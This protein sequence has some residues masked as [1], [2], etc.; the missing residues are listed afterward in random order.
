MTYQVTDGNGDTV[1][2]LLNINVDD[3]TPNDITPDPA[4]I[5]NYV[6]DAQGTATESLGFFGNVGADIPGTVVFVNND[7]DNKL[8]GSINGNPEVVLTSDGNEILLSG[9]GTNTLMGLVDEDGD[10]VIDPGEFKILEVTL[11]PDGTNA[12]NDTYTVELFGTIDAG[13]GFSFDSF[14]GAPAGLQDFIVL[15]DPKAVDQD[16]D[17]VF[18]GGDPG[19]NEVNTS[20]F[21]IGVDA[22]NIVV[23]KQLRLDYVTGAGG[24]ESDIT[25][26]SFD[27]HYFVNN[28]SF[29]IIQTG[30]NANN[31]VDA[32]VQV[33]DSLD[34][35]DNNPA[36]AYDTSDLTDDMADFIIQVQVFDGSGNL[37]ED[38][39]NLGSFDD[40]DIVITFDPFSAGTAEG[41]VL[42][43]GL[44][45]TYEVRVTTDDG[46]SRMEITNLTTGPSLDY[47][48]DIDFT[49]IDNVFVTSPAANDTFDLGGFG[50]ASVI[51][52]DP[53]DI[54][55]D[56]NIL[57]QDNDPGVGMLN[58][59]LVPPDTFV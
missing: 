4:T 5:V 56:L 3:D 8:R 53:I 17:L 46:F 10:G 41:G 30:A 48:A 43:E 37:L 23:N 35:D 58:L 52:P 33:Y 14:A 21:A 24:T 31:R 27:D 38:T 51:S 26:L 16:Q 12:I 29:T 57:D 45:E 36:T 49:D 55:L 19:I 9:F 20:S 50:I 32:W 28:A 34:T 7:I 15:Q 13:G 11:N 42:V 25:T 1:D 22:Q 39:D 47:M 6:N 18:T 59:E 54:S 44:L 40:A 2:G